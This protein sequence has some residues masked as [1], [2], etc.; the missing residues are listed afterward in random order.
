[1]ARYLMHRLA[2]AILAVGA[3]IALL[4]PAKDMD[5]C[6][7]LGLRTALGW[8]GCEPGNV[9]TIRVSVLGLSAILALVVYGLGS[10]GSRVGGRLFGSH[11]GFGLHA[12]ARV[13]RW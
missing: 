10:F 7:K 8:L 5:L 11:V 12:R 3:G 6:G 4:T 13:L 2:L 1:M 9:S